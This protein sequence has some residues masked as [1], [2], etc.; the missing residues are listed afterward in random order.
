MTVFGWALTVGAGWAVRDA[1]D[2]ASWSSPLP[3]RELLA[4]FGL[5]T[6]FQDVQVTQQ[7]HGDAGLRASSAVWKPSIQRFLRSVF[8]SIASREGT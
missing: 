8:S 2:P 6:G 5:V 1:A 7:Q 3:R 4:V